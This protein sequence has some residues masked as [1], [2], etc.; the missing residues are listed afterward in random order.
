MKRKNNKEKKVKEKMKMQFSSNFL[1][2]HFHFLVF[3][4]PFLVFDGVLMLDHEHAI[5]RSS[6]TDTRKEWCPDQQK[7]K[8]KEKMRANISFRSSI[9]CSHLLFIFLLF[10]LIISGHH[11][12]WAQSFPLSFSYW[13]RMGPWADLRSRFQWKWRKTFNSPDPI[14]VEHNL[15]LLLSSST[16][17]WSSADD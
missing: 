12:I 8:E 1:F 9:Y 4:F 10:C 11:W 5:N 2:F 15:H 16:D 13:N 17:A 7:K 6:R 3:P 14:T